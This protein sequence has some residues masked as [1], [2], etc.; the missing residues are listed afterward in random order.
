MGVLHTRFPRLQRTLVLL[1]SGGVHITSWL[2]LVQ[3]GHTHKKHPCSLWCP[4][5]GRQPL[6]VQAADYTALLHVP[7]SYKITAQG[8]GGPCERGG[9]VRPV[10]CSQLAVHPG[11]IAVFR[12]CRKGIRTKDWGIQQGSAGAPR[13]DCFQKCSAIPDVA[14]GIPT[15]TQPWSERAPQ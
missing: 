8:F 9:S 5:Q 1:L 11:V 3:G 12:L 10:L 6:L 14:G 4:R 15:R 13:K 7:S 2:D